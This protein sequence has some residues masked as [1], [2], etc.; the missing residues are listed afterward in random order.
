MPQPEKHHPEIDTGI[1]SLLVLGRAIALTDDPLV[2]FA[3]LLHDVG[4]GATDPALWPRHIGHEKKGKSLVDQL[5]VRLTVPKNYRELA[6]LVAEHHGRCHQAMEMR[7]D[8]L[9][10]F[11]ESLDLFRRPERLEPFLTACIADAQGRPG[12]EDCEYPQAERVR[13]AYQAALKPSAKK[14]IAEGCDGKEVGKQLAL[15]RVEAI[16]AEFS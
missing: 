7:P 9:L 8:T 2:R 15:R 5:C 12:S 6:V 16:A 3:A 11:L 4:K 13:R 14:L 1:H 10:R